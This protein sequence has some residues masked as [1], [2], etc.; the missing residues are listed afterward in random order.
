MNRLLGVILLGIIVAVIVLNYR[1]LLLFSQNHELESASKR[2]VQ[3]ENWEKAV[4]VYED[5]VKRY[6]DNAEA[7]IR[8]GWYYYKNHQADKAE[9]AYRQ[10]LRKDSENLNARMGLANLLKNERKRINEA[11]DQ[12]RMALKKHPDD[13]VLLTQIGNLYVTAAESPDEKREGIQKQLY[14]NAAYYYEQSGK[15]NPYQF[16]TQFN[17]GVAYQH[18]E[19]LQPA[20]KAYCAALKMNPNSYEARYN[21]GLVLT[22]LNFLAEGYRQMGQAVDLLST[23]GSM[24]DAMKMAQLVQRVKNSVY[25]D[26]D[27]KGLGQEP[28]PDFIDAACLYKPTGHTESADDTDNKD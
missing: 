5:G 24:Q 21:L 16:Q 12:F 28:K 7:G 9:I 4:Q 3:V 20:A 14:G 25:N 1:P 19:N 10:V 2:A 11:V 26:P 8:L 18:L 15:V 17:L 13:A 27:K 6:P 23:Q 22:N